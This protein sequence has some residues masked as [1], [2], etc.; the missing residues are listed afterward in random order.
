M[1][2]KARKILLIYP[3]DLSVM[4]ILEAKRTSLL[5]VGAAINGSYNT[6]TLPQLAVEQDMADLLPREVSQQAACS[7]DARQKIEVGSGGRHGARFVA[8]GWYN[9]QSASPSYCNTWLH[10]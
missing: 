5:L 2:G 4:I 9:C 10:N 6:A 8:P 1:K 7:L 3:N